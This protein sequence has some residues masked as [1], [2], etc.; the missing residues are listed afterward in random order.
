MIGLMFMMFLNEWLRA[1]LGLFTWLVL[2]HF[3]VVHWL[4]PSMLHTWLVHSKGRS[5]RLHLLFILLLCRFWNKLMCNMFQLFSKTSSDYFL[6]LL[7]STSYRK[8][9]ASFF[10]IK[11]KWP[12]LVVNKFL[13]HFGHYFASK[14]LH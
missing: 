2:L 1:L 11:L 5:R 6:Q 4:L 13:L 8:V 10:N 12:L 9:F 3:D 14:T 7:K